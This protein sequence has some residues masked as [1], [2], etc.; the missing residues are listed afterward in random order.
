MRLTCCGKGLHNKCTKDLMENTS[1]TLEQKIK[2]IMCRTENNAEGSKEDIEQ[3]HEWT[4]KGKPWAMGMLGQRYI[5]GVG[6]KQSDK[7]GIE[8]Y[9]MAA[10]GGLA[11][12]QAMLGE[13]YRKGSHGLTQSSKRAVALFTLAAKQGLTD[14]QY[15]LGSMYE[16]GDGIGQSDKKAIEL[17][18]MA[19]KKGNVGAQYNLG[20]F[21]REGSHG[22]TQSDKKSIE[23]YT[24]AADQGFVEA[25]YNLGLMYVSGKS[26]E[27]SFSK[28]R[29]WW[30]KAAAQGN[31]NA[32]DGL[33]ELDRC[34]L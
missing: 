6:V 28:A 15:M 25:Q 1:M 5:Q 30:T 20:H 12:A 4:K 9:E 24:L 16:K 34:G 19:A 3:L 8:L 2:C 22:L 27:Q 11:N 7:K 10:E 26:I 29:E 32:I 18:E 13:F 17:F 23:F 21:Y 14:A 33:K 31:K